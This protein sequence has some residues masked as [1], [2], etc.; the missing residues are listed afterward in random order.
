MLFVKIYVLAL[1]LFAPCIINWMQIATVDS[2]LHIYRVR[3]LLL[4]YQYHLCA[5][6]VLQLINFLGIPVS[7]GEPPASA[8]LLLTINK[9]AHRDR[10]LQHTIIWCN[11]EDTRSRFYWAPQN[12]AKYRYNSIKIWYH[13][14]AFLTIG[15]QMRDWHANDDARQVMGKLGVDSQSRFLETTCESL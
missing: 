3:W 2:C 9:T 15:V 6:W 11:L 5:P 13:C 7:V 4:P 10:C 1:Q 12:I 14:F 8:S